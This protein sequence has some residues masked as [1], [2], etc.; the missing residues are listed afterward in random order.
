MKGGL[1]VLQLILAAK[2]KRGCAKH[3]H[4]RPRVRGEVGPVEGLAALLP[5]LDA[6]ARND[7]LQ[8]QDVIEVAL[9]DSFSERALSALAPA[10]VDPAIVLRCPQAVE[11]PFCARGAVLASEASSASQASTKERLSAAAAAA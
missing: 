5:D 9:G 10:P 7:L 11:V 4:L 2:L 1:T 6:P 8:G 3:L